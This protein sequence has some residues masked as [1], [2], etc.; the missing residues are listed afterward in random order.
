MAGWTRN[1]CS[2][3][4]NLEA[5]LWPHG[6]VANFLDR[7]HLPTNG[8]EARFKTIDQGLIHGFEDKV[9]STAD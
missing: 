6:P 8:M 4:K 9:C 1:L 7:N 5:T 2:G 3:T